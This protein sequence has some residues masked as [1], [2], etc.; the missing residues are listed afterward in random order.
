MAVMPPVPY[1]LGLCAE[2]AEPD[3][4]ANNWKVLNALQQAELSLLCD[5]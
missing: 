4:Q 3:T 1:S 5:V 2:C